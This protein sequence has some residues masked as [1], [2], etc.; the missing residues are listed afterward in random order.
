MFRFALLC[1]FVADASA[2]GCCSMEDRQEVLNA[3]E[4]LWSAEY[5]GRRVMI[6]Q[7]AFQKLFEKAPDSKALFTRVNVDNIGSPQFRAHCIRVTNG[8]DTIINM[9][10]DTDVLEE[11]LTHL[12]NQH[13]KYQG[14][15]AAYLTHFRESFAEIL[16]QAIPCFNTA[17]WNRCITA[18]QDK[19]GASLAA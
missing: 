14:M 18:M 3:W 6:A 12:G 2:E 8:F 15:R 17:A 4:A 11:L 1:A 16:P 19:I 7:A 10:F 13:T 9:A 5:T